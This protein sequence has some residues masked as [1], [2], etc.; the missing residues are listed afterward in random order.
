MAENATYE[1]LRTEISS[2]KKSRSESSRRL[3]WVTDDRSLAL[4]RD[5]KGRLEV[6]VLGDELVASS[7]AVADI[8]DHQQWEAD[9]D[10]GISATRIVLPRGEHF[11]Q[12]GA[13]LCVELIEHEVAEDPQAAFDAVEP[14]IALALSRESIGDLTLMGLIGEL[15]LLEHLLAAVPPAG[16]SEI[17]HSWAGSA[18]S[19]RDFQLGPIGIEVKT[20]QGGSSIHHIQGVHQVELGSSNEGVIETHL[21]LLSLGIDWAPDQRQG[22][23]L[24]E[25]V[26]AVLAHLHDEGDR[27]DLR[28][29]VKQYGGDAAIGYDHIRD[30]ERARFGLRFY[31]RFERLYDMTDERIKV[32]T[33][34]DLDGLTNVDPGSVAFRVVLPER[35]RGDLNPITGWGSITQVCLGAGGAS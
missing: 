13:L 18:P 33:R 5:S 32:L 1:W 34:A 9:D 2:I 4:S 29:R 35:I 27:A 6:F 12:F 11:D 21:L 22:Q 25:L 14:L 23:S 24:P 28:A 20:T 17:L 15:A 8:L 31:F 26:D 19:A 7:R 10:S 16:R 3:D 30:K